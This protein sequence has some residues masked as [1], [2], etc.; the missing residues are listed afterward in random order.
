MPERTQQLP[1]Q[2]EL[3]GLLTFVETVDAELL[4]VEKWLLSVARDP[5]QAGW[6]WREGGL[7]FLRC[8]P[9][10]TAIRFPAHLVRAAARSSEPAVV[11]AYLA[12]VLDGGPVIGANGLT[13]YYALV[14]PSASLRWKHPDVECLAWGTWL[15]VPPIRQTDHGS[16][17]GYWVVPMSGPGD[18]CNVDAVEAVRQRGHERLGEES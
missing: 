9:L 15:G 2:V 4:P 1:E 18:L 17:E 16:P 11:D 13:C 14:P 7:T 12:E 3:T 5:R 8:G 10:F 6:E